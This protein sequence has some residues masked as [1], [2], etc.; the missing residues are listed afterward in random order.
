MFYLHH[1]D[2]FASKPYQSIYLAWTLSK[3]ERQRV[4]THILHEDL[5]IDDSV[6]PQ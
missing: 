1:L 2:V 5:L 4:Q 3:E 6:N